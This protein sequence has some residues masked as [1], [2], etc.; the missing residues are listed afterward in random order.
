M[1]YGRIVPWS[2][3]PLLDP[4]WGTEG[5]EFVH[6]GLEARRP[7]KVRLLAEHDW[8]LQSLRV[9]S[10]SPQNALN[11]GL[12]EKCIRTMLSL[13]AV[14]AL[15][16]CPTFEAGLDPRRVARMRMK[17][18]GTLNYAQMN[19]DALQAAGGQ[20]Q[21]VRALEKAMRRSRQ[22]MQMRALMLRRAPRLLALLRCFRTGATS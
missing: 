16:R 14:G 7:E 11:C 13:Q 20:Q 15:G 10:R 9:C 5:L 12:C 3:H 21:F 6:D 2:S 19:L 8:V 4:L 22:T 18:D 17:R 1:F